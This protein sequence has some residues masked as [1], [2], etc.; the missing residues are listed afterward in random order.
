M[1]NQRPLVVVNGTIQQMVPSVLTL[2]YAAS[3]TLDFDPALSPY[4]KV[5]LAGDLTLLSPSS[6]LGG[7]RALSLLIIGDGSTRTLTFPAWSFLG[8][9]APATLAAGKKAV[10]SLTS[11]GA[12]DADVIAAYAAVP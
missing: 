12:L 3:I 10:L 8:S 4:Q 1:S 2:A 9:A 7:G 6:N 11:Y 5:T